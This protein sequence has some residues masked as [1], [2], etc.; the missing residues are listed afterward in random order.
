[1]RKFQVLT[2]LTLGH[3]IVH[4]YRGTFWVILPL[5]ASELQLSFSQVGLLISIRSLSTAVTNLPAGA[6]TDILRRRRLV[7]GITLF[8]LGISYF[9]VGLTSHFLVII[10]AL[11]VV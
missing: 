6:A 7:I 11:I 4:W 1:M 5:L 8:W 9:A 3:A 2:G 10:L